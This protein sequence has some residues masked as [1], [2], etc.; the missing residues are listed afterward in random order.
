[1]VREA[2]VDVREER[3]VAYVV[4]DAARGEMLRSLRERLPDYMVP[5]VF[6]AL[7]SLPLTPNG[8]VD[9]KALPAPDWQ[10]FVED[11]QAPRT[12]IE[13]TLAG[14]WGE[15]LG[16]ERIGISDRFFD[17]GGHSL[18]ATR[19][20]S[21]IREA[22]GIEIPLRDLFEAPALSDLAARVDSALRAGA[23]SAAPPLVPV[24]RE[25]P[26]PLSFAQQ[27]LWFIDRFQPGGALYN[28]PVALRIE[29]PLSAEVLSRCLGEV[30]R[31]HEAL[32]TVFAMQDGAPVQVVQP[33]QPFL[34]P[35]VDLS[36]QPDP[37]GHA[38]V[39]AQEEARRPFDL[40]RGPLLRGVLLRLAETDHILALT[41]HH[42]VSDGWSMGILVR[43]I[44]ALY[45]AL[46]ESR[47]D[48]LPDL[49]VQYADF[50]V[51]Q[52]SW[53]R[54]ELL[55]REISF[56]RRQLADL[57]PLLELPTDRPRPAVRSDRGASRSLR[58]PS[59]ITGQ[60]EALARRE[61]ATPFMV[62]LAAFQALLARTSG[63][64]DLA[65]GTPVAG[66]NRM[67]IEGLI[68]FFVNTL[69]MRGNLSGDPSFLEL[70]G[71]IWATA[72]AA[73]THQEVPFE[74]LVEELAPERSLAHSSLFQVM[75]ALQNAPVEGAEIRGLRVQPVSTIGTTAKFDLSLSLSLGNDGLTGTVEHATDLFDATTIE[76]LIVQ[77][78]RLLVGALSDP[79]RLLADLPLLV[80]AEIHQLLAEWN[81][82]ATGSP[83][84][85]VE[86]FEAQGRRTPDAVAVV[87]ESAALTYG[88]LDLR[89]EHLANHL[90]AL[91]VG[92]EIP[93]GLCVEP[94]PD[95]VVGILGIFKSGGVH[96]P[97]DPAHPPARLAFILGDS[98][99]P[100]LVT[101][102][103]HLASLPP[104]NAH[105]VLLPKVGEGLAPSRVGGGAGGVNRSQLAY[106]IYT[107]G[108]TGQPKAVQ[109]EHGMLA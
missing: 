54:G 40:A 97:L 34:L 73:Y 71:R 86:L 13:E 16:L 90:R 24:T 64:E 79:G 61:G 68:G 100:V 49:P 6:V 1:G 5:A 29:G 39:L 96:L 88:E 52:G 41:M 62:L 70:L 76:R 47:S 74:K 60:A 108:T 105:V 11:Y 23:L 104:H 30:T 45:A 42:I 48:L 109:I 69:V 93:V 107:S 59:E 20:L 106:L 98:S 78:E 67:E 46:F 94:S 92:P 38:G 31:R 15:V 7:D 65:V 33:A 18:L 4:G 63:Q 27:R 57:P 89:A 8:K 25:G 36:R 51:W 77:Y 37:A 85:V 55:E 58:L 9:R 14:I 91:G 32:R 101:L 83:M 19:V 44:T 81:D 21:R 3:L 12:P 80:D 2:V 82:T 75:F 102:P 22:F 35:L 72:L 66:R 84:G 10:G 26:L 43:E 50:A 103:Q 53:L 99:A 56:W 28:M 17:R 95:L 87:L